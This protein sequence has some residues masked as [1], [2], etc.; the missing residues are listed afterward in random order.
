MKR[1]LVASMHHESNSFNPI[2]AGEKDFHV[3][4]GAESLSGLKGNDPF[5]GVVKTLR[6]QGYEVIPTL[7]AGAVPNGE[8]D[9]DFYLGLKA[10]IIRRAREAKA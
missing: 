9:K 3:E 2:V 10:E 5:Y 1:V 6:D 7:S 4:R 8:V